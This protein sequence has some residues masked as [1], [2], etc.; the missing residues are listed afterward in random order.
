MT[1]LNDCFTVHPRKRVA[2]TPLYDWAGRPMPT[3]LGDVYGSY[4]HKKLL[5]MSIVVG[6][7]G[8]DRL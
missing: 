7:V 1:N 8:D 6:F 3:E 5:R 4:S 2:R